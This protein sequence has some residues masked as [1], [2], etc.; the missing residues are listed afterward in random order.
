[1]PLDE[2]HVHSCYRSSLG[3]L[4]LEFTD[5]YGHFTTDDW[6][7]VD[8][9]FIIWGGSEVKPLTALGNNQRWHKELLDNSR[10]NKNDPHVPVYILVTCSTLCRPVGETSDESSGPP[11]ARAAASRRSHENRHVVSQRRRR[12]I[13]KILRSPA[14]RRQRRQT[15]H[16]KSRAPT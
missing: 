16:K 6:K 9:A 12:A 15:I 1:M 13:L 2:K 10:E 3:L 8:M 4:S 14:T 5:I 11:A 7:C